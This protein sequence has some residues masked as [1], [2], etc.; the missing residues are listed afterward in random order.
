MVASDDRESG[1]A[2]IDST[3]N[4]GGC[5]G[6]EASSG[7]RWVLSS[8]CVCD[9]LEEAEGFLVRRDSTDTARYDRGLLIETSDPC[10]VFTSA[11]GGAGLT[12]GCSGFGGLVETTFELSF[13]VESAPS[14]AC[15]N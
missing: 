13:S 3:V 8:L 10:A 5:G 7:S 11:S 15:A 12:D 1:T 14:A 2:S 6:D 4:S 9:D